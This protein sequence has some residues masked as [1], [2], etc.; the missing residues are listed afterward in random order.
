MENQAGRRLCR[1]R[2]RTWK[3]YTHSDN[4]AINVNGLRME[5]GCYGESLIRVRNC[6]PKRF[7]VCFIRRCSVS[8]NMF[9]VTRRYVSR[10]WYP[11]TDV[12]IRVLTSHCV[13][14]DSNIANGFRLL[15]MVGGKM[16]T[17]RST[18]FWFH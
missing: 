1:G 17:F 4:T 16:F 15:L 18:Y 11:T 7:I 14:F 5:R 2:N 8:Y 10:D 9:L 12:V 3:L 13:N 6:Y